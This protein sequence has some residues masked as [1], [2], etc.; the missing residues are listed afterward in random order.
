M[1]IPFFRFQFQIL[2]EKKNLLNYSSVGV[3]PDCECSHENYLFSAYINECY[4]ECGSGSSGLYPHCRCYTP[5][6]YYDAAEFECKSYIGRS[7]PL[8]SIGIG[9]DCLCVQEN[10]IFEKSYWTC[11]PG[12]AT[13]AYPSLASCPDG[14]KWPQCGVEIDRN[15]LLSLVG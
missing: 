11:Y 2:N 3:Y 7:C 9:P 6:T 13:F 12:N 15:T 4:I 8:A 5:E 1:I 14:N 10:Y